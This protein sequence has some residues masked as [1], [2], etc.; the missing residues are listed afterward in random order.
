MSGM[1]H[2]YRIDPMIICY[3]GIHMKMSLG[4]ISALNHYLLLCDLEERC[5]YA[6]V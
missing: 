3:E 2:K 6:L 4:H 5:L 1:V